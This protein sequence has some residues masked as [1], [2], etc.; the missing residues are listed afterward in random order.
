MISSI[1]ELGWAPRHQVLD[2]VRWRRRCWNTTSD[3]FGR[4]AIAQGRPLN[5]E[6]SNLR[7]LVRQSSWIQIHTDGG[8]EGQG[9]SAAATITVWFPG[10]QDNQRT[11]VCARAILLEPDV[12]PFYAEACALLEALREFRGLIS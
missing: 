5:S 2:L 8:V 6:H 1:F 4:C 11:I 12:T 10:K 7:G 9:A 3:L